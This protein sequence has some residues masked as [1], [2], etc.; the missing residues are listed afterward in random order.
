[1]IPIPG[2]RHCPGSAGRL[3]FA[4]RQAAEDDLYRGERER[5]GQA[6]SEA[7][8]IKE[9]RRASQARAYRQSRFKVLTDTPTT[10]A[11]SSTLKPV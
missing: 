8:P 10:L 4:T 9:L 3:F 5:A 1:M 6:A 11:V 7:P 2:D